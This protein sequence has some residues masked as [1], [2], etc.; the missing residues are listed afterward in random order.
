MSLL[1]DARHTFRHL[2]QSPGFTIA[3]VLTFAIAIGSNSAIFSAVNTVL[4]RPL[5]VSAPEQL[6]VIWQTDHGGQAVIELTHRHLREWMESG[7]TF[8][9]AS[10]MGSHNWNAVASG[11]AVS[12]APSSTRSVSRPCSD[13]HSVPKTMCRMVRP[14]RC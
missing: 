3:T 4:L 10:L 9:H 14:L 12:P 1:A 2:R 13:A 6:A 11:S 8:T 5:P 7:S